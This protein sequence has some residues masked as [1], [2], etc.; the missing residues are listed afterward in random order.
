MFFNGVEKEIDER[1]RENSTL[2]YAKEE[3]IMAI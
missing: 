3:M 1:E 2:L